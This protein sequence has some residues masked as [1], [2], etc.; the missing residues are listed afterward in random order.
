MLQRGRCACPRAQRM[1]VSCCMRLCHSRRA[2]A[3]RSPE[4]CLS[5]HRSR[6]PSSRPIGSWQQRGAAVLMTSAGAT[7]P[8]RTSR[9]EPVQRRERVQVSTP[10]AWSCRR[11]ETPRRSVLPPQ[12]CRHRGYCLDRRQKCSRLRAFAPERRGRRRRPGVATAVQAQCHRRRARRRVPRTRHCRCKSATAPAALHFAE[13][14]RGRLRRPA[15]LHGGGGAAR[16]RRTNSSTHP[17]VPK[18]TARNQ[19]A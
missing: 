5:C 10:K 8:N 19:R 7:Q 6:Q 13:G 12:H 18:T 1:S 17:S 16:R 15:A 11:P 9:A 14:R 3:T 2:A 4:L